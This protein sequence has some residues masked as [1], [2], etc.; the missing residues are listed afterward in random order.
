[1]AIV[2]RLD[3]TIEHWLPL[4]GPGIAVTVSTDS[5]LTAVGCAD[6][7]VTI[8]PVADAS[9]RFARARSNALRSG[10]GNGNLSS[11]A[12]TARSSGGTSMPVSGAAGRR[13]RI[14]V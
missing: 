3:G 5:A 8:W 7:A 2:W 9:K 11:A 12:A 10:Q 13:W 6:G 1:M 4:P 14:Q